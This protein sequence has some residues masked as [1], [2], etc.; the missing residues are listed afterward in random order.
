MC[1]LGLGN[2]RHVLST[3][4]LVAV[5]CGGCGFLWWFY[6]LQSF[7]GEELELHLLAGKQKYLAF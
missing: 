4:G 1:L 2:T 3:S 5:F 6:L 7:S